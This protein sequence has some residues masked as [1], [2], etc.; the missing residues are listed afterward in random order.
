MLQYLLGSIKE[1]SPALRSAGIDVK[2]QR[3]ESIA[4]VDLSE[5][6]GEEQCFSIHSGEL[7]KDDLLPSRWQ[8]QHG[9]AFARLHRGIVAQ[10][11]VPQTKRPCPVS[12]S[13]DTI[14]I[15]C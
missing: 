1:G 6:S 14:P 2:A 3:H 13:D 15:A 9:A 8:Q 11:L 5:S 12:A 7:L 4:N 10:D